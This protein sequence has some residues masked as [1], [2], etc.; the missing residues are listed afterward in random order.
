MPHPDEETTSEPPTQSTMFEE[1]KEDALL[2][3]IQSSEEGEKEI[4]S[5]QAGQ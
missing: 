1:D 4:E 2:G 3:H 5:E